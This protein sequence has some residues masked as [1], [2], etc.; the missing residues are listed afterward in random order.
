MILYDILYINSMSYKIIVARYNEDI[1]WLS[2]DM[3]HVIIYNKG[4]P[5]GLKNEILLENVGRESHTYLH[6]II[7]NYENL[8]DVVIFT[9]GN[10]ADHRENG[11]IQ[12]LLT[13]KN[14][15]LLYGKSKYK[16]IHYQ[17]SDPWN[18]WNREW[19]TRPNNQ[20]FLQDNYYK[21]TPIVFGDWFTQHIHPD[22]PNPIYLYENAIFSV[23]KRLILQ[24]PIEY[25][26]NL[27][28]QVNHHI[29]PSEGH[30]FE[31]SWYYIFN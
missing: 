10:I 12:Y 4:T 23:T 15:A 2:S 28:L 25:Y 7:E 13:C 27:I 20:F 31:R 3:D 1:N 18:P 11:D 17:N 6:Y 26:K 29:N 16:K 8:P 24:H 21:N 9:Q 19:N 14:D 30:F 22:Y 5:L